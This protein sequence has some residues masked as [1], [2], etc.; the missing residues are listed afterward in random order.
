MKQVLDGEGL[1]AEFVAPRLWESPRGIDGG[2]TANDPASRQW[3]IAR[4][5]AGH[6]HRQRARHQADRAVARPRRHVHPRIEE[7]DRRLSAPGRGDQRAARLRRPDADC[8][9]AETERADGPGLRPDDRPRPGPGARD[10]RSEPRGR[11]DRDGPRAAG[12]PRSVRR[13]G[14][15]PVARASCGACT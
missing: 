12:R 6:R 10:G 7:R 4:S 1:I 11:P 5:K 2:F 15:R 3:A 8:H 14:L 13:D 9:R